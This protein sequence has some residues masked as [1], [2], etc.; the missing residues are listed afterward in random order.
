MICMPMVKIP[1]IL[2]EY[3]LT[4]AENLILLVFC[5]HIEKKAITLKFHKFQIDIASYIMRSIDFCWSDFYGYSKLK[6]LL[7]VLWFCFFLCLL[8]G[9]VDGA[10]ADVVVDA[11]TVLV[12]VDVRLHCLFPC[13]RCRSSRSTDNCVKWYFI[14][15]KLTFEW[16]LS[17]PIN[18]KSKKKKKK[19]R[20]LCA[21]GI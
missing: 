12:V 15:R 14:I 2:F 6:P 11:A 17:L 20:I 3:W 21:Y 7:L 19:K 10:A 5:V 9:T 4:E 1:Y 18:M 16:T 13:Q 8:N